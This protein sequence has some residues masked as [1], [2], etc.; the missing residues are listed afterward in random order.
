MEALPPIF[1]SVE[2]FHV[3]VIADGLWRVCFGGL[4]SR[5]FF[6]SRF[7]D[8]VAGFIS[9]CFSTLPLYSLSWAKNHH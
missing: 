9:Y 4:I 1:S 6:L 3:G 8:V 2:R 5:R 7:Y